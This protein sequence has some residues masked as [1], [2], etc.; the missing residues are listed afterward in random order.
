MDGRQPSHAVVTDCPLVPSE[1][2][3]VQLVEN[4]LREDLKP[5]EQARA[6]RALMNLNGWSGNQLAK[7][8]GVSQSGVV[9]ALALLELGCE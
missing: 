1:L 7:E 9:Q 6:F 5:I 8:L 2:L 3:A 4:C